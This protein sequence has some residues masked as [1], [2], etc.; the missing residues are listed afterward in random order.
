MQALKVGVSTW[1]CQGCDSF[2]PILFCDYRV[3][4]ISSCAHSRTRP[5]WLHSGILCALYVFLSLVAMRR[6]HTNN[7]V[8]QSKQAEQTGRVPP[9]R[10]P[11]PIS[12]LIAAGVFLDGRV[13]GKGRFHPALKPKLAHE[14]GQKV[15]SSWQEAGEEMQS[16]SAAWLGCSI[17]SSHSCLY[18]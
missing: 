1:P 12:D 5:M 9:P 13:C 2:G 11:P 18:A 14:R 7:R 17:W 15:A 4:G 16:P 6:T 8:L 3:R 10:P